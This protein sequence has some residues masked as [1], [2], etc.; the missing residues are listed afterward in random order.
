MCLVF[1]WLLTLS[2]VFSMAEKQICTYYT[3]VRVTSADCSGRMLEDL[4]T[5]LLTDIQALSMSHNRMRV[6]HSDSFRRYTHLKYLYLDDNMISY[7]EN[8]TFEPLQNLEVIRLSHNALETVPVGVLQLPKLRKLYVDN[9]R[10]KGGGGFEFAPTSETLELLSL[11]NCHLEN[12]PPLG[13]YPRLLELNISGNELKVLFPQQIAP[14]CRLHLLDLRGNP[15]LFNGSGGCECHSLATWIQQMNIYYAE[16]PLNCSTEADEWADGQFPCKQQPQDEM[17][18]PC[19]AASVIEEKKTNIWLTWILPSALVV[20]CLYI[21]L[22]LVG[23]RFHS[24]I[25]TKCGM[26]H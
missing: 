4:P 5:E 14:M 13:M 8:G 15:M 21:V 10:L 1:S 23:T 9:N 17:Q 19:R 6:L 7:V 3:T 22:L 18:T 20:A 16:V 11:A 25:S 2:V 26:E 12:L 24:L